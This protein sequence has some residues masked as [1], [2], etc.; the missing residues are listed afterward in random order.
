VRAEYTRAGV[1]MTRAQADVEAARQR[2]SNANNRE[3]VLR[4]TKEV[5]EVGIDELQRQTRFWL[6]RLAEAGVKLTDQLGTLQGGD[7]SQGSSQM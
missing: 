1:A 3:Q 2:L 5:A 6:K 4:R 7:A